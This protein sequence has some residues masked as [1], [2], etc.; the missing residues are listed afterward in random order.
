M[1]KLL[2]AFLALC[3]FITGCASKQM[4]PAP[5]TPEARVLNEGQS[6]VVFF[7]DTIIGGGIQAPVAEVKNG[8]IFLVG[9]LSAN[10]KILHHTVPGKHLYIIGGG[11]S[12]NVLDADLAPGKFHYV[13]VDPK[14]G[15]MLARFKFEPLSASEAL[16]EKESKNI[17][18]CELMA[19]KPNS[20]LW[21]SD[22]RH[23]MLRRV[24]NAALQGDLSGE[25]DKAVILPAYG[26][27][28]LR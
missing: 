26:I 18:S 1:Q 9:V 8:D 25:K 19:L 12:S 7:R 11:E 21:F 4:Q 16:S 20:E 27:D 15:F 6:A 28:A 13:R 22:E 2:F 23:A 3:F 17:A 24:S 14:M 5:I 10:T